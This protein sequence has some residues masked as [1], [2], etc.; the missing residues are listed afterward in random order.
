MPG[1][2]I[3]FARNPPPGLAK[4]AFLIGGGR[5]LGEDIATGEERSTSIA[6]SI[7]PLC[8]GGRGCVGCVIAGSV[9]VGC[10]MNV[11][12]GEDRALKA[13]EVFRSVWSCS[14]VYS[15]CGLRLVSGRVAEASKSSTLNSSPLS[16]PES[17]SL[18]SFL[19]LFGVESEIGSLSSMA[20]MHFQL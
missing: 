4:G 12:G 6:P 10:V 15:S 16:S 11:R 20:G 5:G 3:A 9:C 17:Y 14:F 13:D 19:L 7:L 2:A 1:G 18:V 8:F